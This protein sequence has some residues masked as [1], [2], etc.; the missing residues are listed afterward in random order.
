[1][2]SVQREFA[3]ERRQLAEYIRKDLV[4]SKFF[5]VSQPEEL[6]GSRGGDPG[7]VS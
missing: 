2:S 7:P 1:M 5:D 4:F 3:R 6:E